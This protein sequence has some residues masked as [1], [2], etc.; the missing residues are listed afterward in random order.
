[1]IFDQYSRYKAS[2]DL[3]MQAGLTSANSILDVGSGPECLFGQFLPGASMNYVDPLIQGEPQQ[4]YISGNIFTT[5]LDGRLFEYVTAVDVLEHVPPESRHAFLDRLASLSKNV[6]LLGFPSTESCDALATD[7]AVDDQYRTV[8]GRDYSW[9][10]E[11]HRFGLPSLAGTVEH[12]GRLGWHCQTI[13]HG[14]APWL[15]ELLAFVVCTWEIPDL[16]HIVLEASEKFNRDLYPS[17]FKEPHY[18]Q[19]VIA[20]RELLPAITLPVGEISELEAESVFRKLMDETLH[21]YFIVSLR[22]LAESD[23]ALVEHDAAIVERDAAIAERNAAIAERNAVTTLIKTI[24][25]SAS[26]RLTRP[27]RFVAR[28]VRYGLTNQDRQRLTQAL[29]HRYHR[30]PLS[31]SAKS[32][33]RFLYHRVYRKTVRSISHRALRFTQFHAPAIRPLAQRLDKPDYVVWG[34]IDWHFRHQRPQQLALALAATGRR[35]LYISPVLAD[36]ERVGFEAEALNASGQL[37]QIKLFAKGAPH[38]YSD[39]P[40]LEIVSQLR[41]SIGEVLDWAGCR[42]IVSL[43]DHPFWYD[44][45][46]VLP[47][48]RLV[49]DCMDHHE[50]FGNNAESMLQLEK[51]LLSEAGLTITTSTWLDEALASHAKHRALIRN[52]GEYKHFA[53]VPDS[54]YR[55]PQGRRIIGYYGAI[56]EWFDLDLVE[57]VARQHPDCSVLLVGADTVNAKSRLAKLHNVTFTGEVPYSQLPHYLHGFD[58]CLLPFKVI[59]L[60]LATNPVKVYE[61]LSAGKPIVTVDLPEMAQ[62][63]G[64]VYVADEQAA[65]LAAVSKVLSQPEPNY[66]LQ[67]RKAFAEGQTWL[68]RAEVLIQT[69][70]S[71]EHDPMVSVVVVTYNNLEFTHACLASLDE[72][73]Q[74]EHME[75]IVVDNASSDGTPTF[76]SEWVAEKSNRKLILNNDNRGFAA[77]N[78]QGLEIADGEFLVLLNNDTYVTPGWIRT[79]MRHLQRD[80]TIGLIGP[81]T[82][83]IGNE[84]KIDIAYDDMGEML[85]K[86]STYTRSHIGQIYPL[87]TAAF[88]CVMLPRTTF[89]LVG[90]LDEAFGRG[91]FEDDDYC[92]RIGHVGL[93]V[94]Y[95][96]DV[97]IHH[98][99]SASFDKLKHQDRKKLFEDN[100]KIY[101]AKWGKWVPHA[102]RS[103][104]SPAQWEPE[105]VPD[106][107]TGQKYIEGHCVVCGKDSRFFYQDVALWRESLNCQHCR[108]TSR[109]RSIARGLLRA[110]NE[111]TGAEASSLATLPRTSDKRL[112]VYDPPVPI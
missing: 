62:F 63:D 81:V 39:A 50:G 65:F 24:K 2:A 37:F 18:R 108:S 74:Y 40:S 70:E 66:L 69:A 22:K 111:L 25:N 13:G 44:M 30:L 73:S 67:K 64:L 88:F 54:I 68:H 51:K 112:S 58:V 105:I 95:A 49:Y 71:S 92:R 55:D 57:A 28:L 41:R 45:A 1:M 104:A 100:K 23:A 10:E 17:D 77:A 16:K 96:E 93:R 106:V 35:V 43:V 109:Y 32:L 97:F 31:A 7:K 19:F 47:N 6:I 15:Q 107:F 102:Y 82:N 72:H 86:S 21:R 53:N 36:D 101:E 56:A 94:V 34:V 33:A 99:L 48:S 98:H 12:L 91:F 78:N 110:I 76:L 90:S 89:E 83:N 52:A 38:I 5:E 60:T 27:L 3:L 84:A 87:R 29:R 61:Y 79:L 75:I 42:Q 20:S 11:H 85:V 59:P 26:W 46:S 8:F 14:H 4:G 80:K 103:H 9:L